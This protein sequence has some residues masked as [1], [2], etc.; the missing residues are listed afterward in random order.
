MTT[1]TTTTSTMLFEMGTVMSYTDSF[2]HQKDSAELRELL[3]DSLGDHRA[4]EIVFK[5]FSDA[6]KWTEDD[7]KIHLD[8]VFQ[9]TE[10]EITYFLSKHFPML[11]ERPNK[12]RDLALAVEH[13][14]H[15]RL[16]ENHF[17]LNIN[18]LPPPEAADKYG[19]IMVH[20][21]ESGWQ[22]VPIEQVEDFVNLYNCSVWTY[23]PDQPAG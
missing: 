1:T 10:P 15:Q 7:V 3:N 22:T 20:A 21:R 5:N 2:E 19:T 16:K 17:E 14:H 6:I 12:K 18:Q 11:R 13:I 4:Q 8:E 9:W 23:T